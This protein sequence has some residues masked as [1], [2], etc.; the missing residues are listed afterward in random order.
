[1]N[2]VHQIAL[3]VGTRPN[4][5]KIS[6]FRKVFSN[7]PNLELK[8]IHSNQHYSD[9][10]SNVFFSQFG[11]EADVILPQFDGH[12]SAHIGHIIQHLTS[13]LMNDR[14][15]LLIVVGDVNTTL[16]GALVGNK[17][18]IKLAHLESGLRSF[19]KSMPE[20]VNRIIVDELSDYFFVTEQSGLDNLKREGMEMKNVFFV[21]NTMIDTLVAFENE[22]SNKK[23]SF[24][25]EKDKPFIAVTLH[26]PSNVDNLEGLH[27]IIELL[28]CCS[29]YYQI[30]FP[31]HPRTLKNIQS[32]ELKRD[33]DAIVNV[34]YT[35]PMDYFTFQKLLSKSCGVIT[36]SGGIQ[37][38]TTFLNV[39]CVTLRDNTERPVTIDLGTNTLLNFDPDTV[40][41]TIND[42]QN[43][44]GQ[45]PPLWD[46]MSSERIVQKIE[47]IFAS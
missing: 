43:E 5:V 1:M 18:G 4:I 47:E 33:F 10:V 24:H 20:E 30:V 3:L 39:P 17:L 44:S 28:K 23:F 7:Y 38:E 35:A 32:F 6:Q 8:I 42:A 2:K 36:D 25:Y 27:N 13:E 16:A 37:E 41:K 26:R 11:I 22:I 14:P 15:D 40:I 9:S 12:A 34:I 31:M 19:D 45:K 46:G 29:K 21:G